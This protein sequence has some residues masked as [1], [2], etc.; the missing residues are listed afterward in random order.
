MAST[1]ACGFTGGKNTIDC[2]DGGRVTDGI[3]V[4]LDNAALKDDE[5]MVD[6][7]RVRS[8]VHGVMVVCTGMVLTERAEEKEVRRSCDDG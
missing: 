3:W 4:K 6:K 2:G 7:V 5:D 1:F 8:C